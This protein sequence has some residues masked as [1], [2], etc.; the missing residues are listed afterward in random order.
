MFRILTAAI[1]V[2]TLA[3]GMLVLTAQPT[4]AS[5]IPDTGVITDRE[6]DDRSGKWK[7]IR[8]W[9]SGGTTGYW[10]TSSSGAT[11]TW[12]LGDVQGVFQ[13]HRLLHGDDSHNGRMR[14]K[15][16]EKRSSDKS[17]Q[18]IATFNPGSQED[19]EG[20]WYYDT[21]LHLD[22]SV[23]IIAE[24][25]SGTVGVDDVRLKQVAMLP[26]YKSA[27]IKNCVVEHGRLMKWGQRLAYVLAEIPV[28]YFTGGLVWWKVAAADIARELGMDIG[29]VDD[30]IERL[31]IDTATHNCGKF[32]WDG[33]RF[34]WER[35]HSPWTDDIAAASLTGKLCYELETSSAG[36]NGCVDIPIR[37]S[38]P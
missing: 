14:W 5:Q 15:V 27:A 34:P 21:E 13:F 1:I 2:L 10:R 20:W 38:R 18:L 37:G 9:Y 32:E 6:P 28:A 25:R 12:R 26:K 4:A 7:R 29:G 11:A 36:T 33:F 35:G 8:D 3:S 30:W 24:R 17:Y 19:R 16:F 31:N 23:K 22:G